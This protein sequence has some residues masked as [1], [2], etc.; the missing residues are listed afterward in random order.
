MAL[1]SFASTPMAEDLSLLG[2]IPR[3]S[4]VATLASGLLLACNGSLARHAVRGVFE[5]DGWLYYCKA[6]RTWRVGWSGTFD[7]LS[8]IREVLNAQIVGEKSGSLVSRVGTTWCL[9]YGGK[10][11]TLAI[12]KWMYEAT[13]PNCI[14]NRKANL[15]W[16]VTQGLPPQS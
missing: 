7:V 9:Q 12:C 1:L 14:M 6:K 15:A 4:K 11:D 5:G 10:M 2:I 8:G 3:K 16:R 13:G